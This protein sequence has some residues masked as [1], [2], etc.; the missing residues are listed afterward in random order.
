MGHD[1]STLCEEIFDL[2]ACTCYLPAGLAG[3]ER[4]PD[5]QWATVLG[6]SRWVALQT[7]GQ[8]GAAED[9]VGNGLLGR[10]K[11]LFRRSGPEDEL[12][13]RG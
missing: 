8:G 10:L 3:V 5:G 2:P 6:L 13:A 7:A 9:G 4:L 11:G 12:T 1:D